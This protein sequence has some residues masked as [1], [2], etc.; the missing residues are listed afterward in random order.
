[1]TE[2]EAAVRQLGKAIQADPRYQA[3]WKAKT[4]NDADTELQENIQAFNLKKMSYQHETE[5]LE[6]KRNPEKLEKLEQDIQALYLQIMENP[7]MQAFDTAKQA[8]NMMMQEVDTILSLCANG[9]D[10]DRCHPDLT[11]CTGNCSSSEMIIGGESHEL[12]RCPQRKTF[13]YDAA[14]CSDQRKIQ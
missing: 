9:E 2:V 13:S 14:V 4:D 8:M 6:E 3:Y 10:P 7:N 1:M 11:N 5:K 12:S